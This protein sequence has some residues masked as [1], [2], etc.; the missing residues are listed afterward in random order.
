ME[1]KE[2][3]L[4]DMGKEFDK[5]LVHLRYGKH[6]AKEVPIAND[7]VNIESVSFEVEYQF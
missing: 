4:F 7:N 6:R 3:Y 5:I 2:S 1:F